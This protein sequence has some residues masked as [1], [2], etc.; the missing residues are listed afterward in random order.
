MQ[1]RRIILTPSSLTET[2]QIQFLFLVLG[3]FLKGSGH[4][5]PLIHSIMIRLAAVK[6]NASLI[7]TSGKV[8]KVDY[9]EPHP[10]P[11]FP[12]PPHFTRHCSS[13]QLSTEFLSDF[14]RSAKS[15]PN[16][17]DPQVNF[18]LLSVT[19]AFGQAVEN[20]PPLPH[21]FN[22]LELDST[23]IEVFTTINVGNQRIRSI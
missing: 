9:C 17:V 11:F 22:Q 14:I 21:G 8:Y 23:S 1:C 16:H 3:S 19:D 12:S 20:D 10:P 13:Q 2:T 7:S 15:C 4:Y 6:G 5:T 18:T